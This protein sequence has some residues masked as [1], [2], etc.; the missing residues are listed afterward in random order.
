M[1]Y[2]RF[3]VCLVGG[4]EETG[5][6][7]GRK[8]EDG[9]VRGWAFVFPAHDEINHPNQLA[10]K[11]KKQEPS[12]REKKVCVGTD[13]GW[14]CAWPGASGRAEQPKAS[15]SS[16]KVHCSGP[17]CGKSSAWIGYATTTLP[18]HACYPEGPKYPDSLQLSVLSNTHIHHI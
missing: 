3:V 11:L 6:E 4:N 17:L 1:I 8:A 16:I 5:R 10:P 9:G 12:S 7:E 14:R 2:S 13:T 18:Q 15:C